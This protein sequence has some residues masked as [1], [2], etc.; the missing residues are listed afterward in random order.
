MILLFLS[1][2]SSYRFNT[3]DFKLPKE[4]ERSLN[5][6]ECLVTNMRRKTCTENIVNRK[7]VICQKMDNER[8]KIV[9]A[10][11]MTA[12]SVACIKCSNKTCVPCAGS[13]TNYIVAPKYVDTIL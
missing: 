2:L 4:N 6:D 3:I 13:S 12:N 9:C 8:V 1:V 5:I 11:Y 7:F 10:T